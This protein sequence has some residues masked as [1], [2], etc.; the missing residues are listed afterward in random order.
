MIRT[1]GY[2]TTIVL[3]VMLSAEAQGSIIFTGSGSTSGGHALAASATFD[4]VNSGSGTALQVTLANT[5][6]YNG[7]YANNWGL[8]GLFWDN[9]GGSALTTTNASAL[10][11]A[12]STIIGQCTTGS[13]STTTTVTCPT[14]S[15]VNVGGEFSYVYGGMP[16]GI[17]ANGVGSSGYLPSSTS[18]GNLNGPNLDNPDALDGPNFSL[19]GP[20]GTGM[21]NGG[22]QVPVIKTSAVFLLPITLP[23]FSLADISN[24]SFQYGTAWTDANFGGTCTSGCGG[25]P[26]QQQ[27]PEPATLAL[28]GLGLVGLGFTRRR[29]VT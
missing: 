13:G 5:D 24:V 8:T 21:T 19:I 3:S 4:I 15:G 11:A 17:G 7:D 16:T 27:V 12:G 26:P 6:G 14:G 20:S 28:V 2:I 29:V 1:L 25:S 18:M 23:S 10:T 9:T 22:N